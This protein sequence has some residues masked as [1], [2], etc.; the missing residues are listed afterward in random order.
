MLTPAFDAEA[1]WLSC[2]LTI[3]HRIRSIEWGRPARR[4]PSTGSPMPGRKEEA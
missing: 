3:A 2:D 1:G 4:S